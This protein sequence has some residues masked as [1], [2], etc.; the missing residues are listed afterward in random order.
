MPK[1]SPLAR[2]F[3]SGLN[4]TEETMLGP[5][6]EMGWP[7]CRWVATFHSR[8]M[9][10]VRPFEL[11]SA[12]VLPSGLNA[13]EVTGPMVSGCADLPTG[14]HVPEPDVPSD[15]AADQGLAVG[16]ERRPS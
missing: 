9:P 14:G 5:V 1:V 6:P 8:T 11:T 4:A 12:R 13:T 2:S 3:P 15:A 16:A 7:I 10:E